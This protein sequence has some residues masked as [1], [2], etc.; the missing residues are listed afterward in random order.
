MARL[1]WMEFSK[2]LAG[3]PKYQLY[4][5]KDDPSEV[6]NLYVQNPTKVKELESLLK[7]YIVEGR[8]TPGKIQKNDYVQ[9][10]E[11]LDWMDD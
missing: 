6:N 1:W 11:Q 4:D 9:K 10:W 7:K 8:S 2:H 3:L 5:L